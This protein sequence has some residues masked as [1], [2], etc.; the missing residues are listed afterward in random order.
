VYNILAGELPD[1]A[2]DNMGNGGCT[3]HAL[4]KLGV[5]ATVGQAKVALNAA[6]EQ[7]LA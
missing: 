2:K 4:F 5:F 1:T 3:A 6:G 7:I